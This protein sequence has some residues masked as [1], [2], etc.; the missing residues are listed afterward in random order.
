MSPQH[1]IA[2]YRIVS[3]LGEGGM[4]AVYRATASRKPMSQET[5]APSDTATLTMQPTIPG[6]ILGTAAYIPRAGGR[7]ASRQARRHWAFGVVTMNCLP[8]SGSL[9]AKPDDSVWQVEYYEIPS[10]VL[11]A[12]RN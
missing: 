11:G 10:R 4:G 7:Q 1:S 12:T 5:S 2:H 8:A 6:V 9:P 3:K